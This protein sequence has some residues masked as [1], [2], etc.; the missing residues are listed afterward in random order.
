MRSVR[1]GARS[2]QLVPPA[3]LAQLEEGSLASANHMEQIAIDMGALLA[4]AFPHLAERADE[5]RDPRFLTRMRRGARVLMDGGRPTLDAASRHRSDTVRG[6][7]AFARGV[8][9]PRATDLGGTLA[10]RIAAIRPFADDEHFA[11]REWAWLAVRPA[12][13]AAPEAAIEALKPWVA[14]DSPNIRRFAVEVTRPRSVWGEHIPLL[15]VKPWLA[16]PILDQAARDAARYVQDSVANWVNDA[17]RSSPAWAREVAM[18]WS[19]D[20]AV[21]NRVLRRATRNLAT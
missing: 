4:N 20:D 3:I 2:P 16:E 1:R 18:R 9:E 12:V 11:V 17:A 8:A 10:N 15:K 7:A 6:W 19:Q 14:D 5:L 21:S 13:A